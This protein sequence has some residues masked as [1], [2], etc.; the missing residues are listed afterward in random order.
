MQTSRPF[1]ACSE[2]PPV[3]LWPPP[4]P[5]SRPRSICWSRKSAARPCNTPPRSAPG[6]CAGRDGC[7][8]SNCSGLLGN[9]PSTAWALDLLLPWFCFI[10]CNQLIRL[11]VL[12]SHSNF[13]TSF[14]V[15]VHLVVSLLGIIWTILSNKW[16]VFIL[17]G[18]LWRHRGRL[19]L[20]VKIC[21]EI[22]KFLSSLTE[23]IEHLAYN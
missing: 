14:L 23:V 12:L 13:T 15:K 1:T 11:S 20:K 17:K 9:R 16:T 22:A 8:L 4:P 19:L 2:S 21:L 18:W 5:A 6:P 3:C 10:N 7:T